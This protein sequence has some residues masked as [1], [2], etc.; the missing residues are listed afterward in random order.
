M[1]LFGMHVMSDSLSLLGG[2]RLERVFERAADNRFKGVL[3][4]AGVTAVI[5]SSSATTVMVVGFVNSG[6]MKL[7]QAIGIIMG[8]NIGTTATA[9][10]LSLAG[11][12]GGNWITDLL[13]PTSF[14]PVLAIVGTAMVMFSTRETRKNIGAILMGFS[15][16]MFGMDTMSTAMEPLAQEPA[17]TNLLTQFSNPLIGVLLGTVITAVIQSSSASVGILQALSL[18]CVVPYSMAIPI[19]MGQN[20]GTCVTALLSCIGANKNAKRA[21]MVHLYFNM[22]GVAIFMTLFYSLNAIVGFSFF[23]QPLGPSN[24]AVIHT[25]FNVMTTIILLP[26]AKGL[27][28]LARFTIR[29][30][31]HPRGKQPL[32]DER[33]LGTPAFALEQC[34][35]L[36]NKMGLLAH[37][38]FTESLDLLKE[39]DEKKAERIVKNE[40]ALDEY[41]DILDGFLAKL[42]GK[43]FSENDSGEMTVLLHMIGDF[44]SIGDHAVNIC[45]SVKEMRKKG[46]AFTP[47]CKKE[48]EVYVRAARDVANNTFEA[49]ENRDSE[50]ASK[51]E[52]LEEVVD[53]LNKE[54]RKRHIRRVRK[55]QC[56]IETGFIFTDILGDIERSSDHCSN[57]AAHIVSGRLSAV[58]AH[59]MRSIAEHEGGFVKRVNRLMEKYSLPSEE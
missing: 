54:L 49:Y 45:E 37:E 26:F 4:G 12:E 15:L 55:G 36:A 25:L 27:E 23:N 30:E 6:V 2:S 57:I 46:G 3:L 17:F 40:D 18:S 10:I 59:G 47:E 20:I 19:I 52:P 50:I 48:L 38:T 9:W 33:F 8:A 35:N 42:A 7:R 53:R 24:I 1:F 51:V 58:N 41:E 39:Y 14:T 28:K 32:L 21:A 56:N 31:K 13:K 16:L 29:D 22:I 44:E 34:R 5:Q 43:E 11:I